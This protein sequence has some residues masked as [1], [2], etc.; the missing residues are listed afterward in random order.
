MPTL[1][2]VLKARHR[3]VVPPPAVPPPVKQ[4]QLPAEFAFPVTRRRPPAGRKI[5]VIGAGFAGLC[6]AY[7]LQRRNYAVT[8]FEAR[9]RIG[10]RVHS[11]SD[12]ARGKAVEG[13]GELIGTNHPLW[14]Y[15]WKQF[16]LSMSPVNDYKNAP[17]RVGGR[18]LTFDESQALLDE[19]DRYVGEL[20]RLA[21]GVKAFAPWTSRH[22]AKLDGMSLE[23]WRQSRRCK[24][25]AQQMACDAVVQQLVADNG[26]EARAQSLLG[27]L[28]MIKGH[29]GQRYWDDTEVYRCRGGN[30]QLALAFVRRL[31]K[32]SVRLQHVL[33]AIEQVERGVRL[34]VKPP[35]GTQRDLVFDDVIVTAP[36]TVW[37]RFRVTGKELRALFSGAPVLGANIKALMRF[38]R[39]FWRDFASSPTLTDD[40]G[41]VDLTWETSEA[42][43]DPQFTLVA[44]AGANHAQTLARVRRPLTLV[45]RQLETPYPGISKDMRA[46]RFM[47]W[48]DD[49]WSRGSYYFPKPRDV[50]R[51][52]PVWHRGHGGVHLAGEHTCYAFMG[53]MEGALHSGYV[54]ARRIA[55]RD[56]LLK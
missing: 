9:D 25:N 11:I 2:S 45:R 37:S 14:M 18:T 3:R 39:R 21:S 27:V 4:P 34:S 38:E 49:P 35:R 44:F 29:G 28:A 43:D 8:V 17:I 47:R 51:F 26:F 30:T 54:A 32:G 31:P 5:A 15:Y 55:A 53:Y 56:G 13:G 23:D 40:R 1:Y 19:M 50:M 52:G 16:R 42:D 20:N 46:F 7:E 41:P 6:A 22:A 12:F 10:G 48:P 24:T 36:P 33:T